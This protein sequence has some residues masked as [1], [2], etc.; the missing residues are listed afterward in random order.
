MMALS[1]E[2]LMNNIQKEGFAVVDLQLYLDTHPTDK[3]ALN[4]FNQHAVNYKNLK[5]TYAKTFE[6]I[7]QLAPTDKY[8]YAW[9][10][11]P[12]PWMKSGIMMNDDEED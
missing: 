1:K 3:T 8:P 7:E 4:K 12:W 11:P 10:L 9:I 5:E 6:P 2:Q